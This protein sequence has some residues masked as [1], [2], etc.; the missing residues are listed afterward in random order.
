MPSE[1]MLAFNMAMRET[2]KPMLNANYDPV[3]MRAI[4]VQAEQ[5]GAPVDVRQIGEATVEM[6]GTHGPA[7]LVYVPG[8]GFCF[9]GGDIHRAFLMRVCAAAGA[10]G[11][12][13]QHRLAPEHAYP[14]AHQDV[15]LVLATL[16]AEHEGPLFLLCDSS[17]GA[18]ALAACQA[19]AADGQRLPDRIVGLS[20]LTDLAMTGLSHVSNAEADPMFGPQAVIHKVHHYLQGQNPTAEGVSPLW[21]AR[22]ALPDCLLI[23][24]SSEV[25]L[26][27]SLR[28]AERARQAGS[29]VQVSIYDEAPHV[30]ALHASLPEAGAA[31]EDIAAF[32]QPG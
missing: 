9:P 12:L 14:A 28:L 21:N 24:G 10:R 11:M 8:G 31:V 15:A 6:Y 13:V 23:V 5:I 1:E 19:M 29:H 2:Q 20:V 4:L 22:A 30:F 17:G 16:G 18:L 7:L 3:A 32:L 26:D 25:M 27:D